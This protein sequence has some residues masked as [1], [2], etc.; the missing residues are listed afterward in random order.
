MG[1]SVL[2][3]Q[4][5]DFGFRISGYLCCAEIQPPCMTGFVFS[6]SRGRFV[7]GGRIR[8]SRIERVFELKGYRVCE[9]RDGSR[10]VICHW[11]YQNGALPLVDIIH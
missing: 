8:T 3:A 5:I 6:E 2:E 1:K 11:W 7:D 10:Y 9:T 4:E